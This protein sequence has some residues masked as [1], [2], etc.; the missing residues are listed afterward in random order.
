M[1]RTALAVVTDLFFVAKLQGV[2]RS[3]GVTL[4]VAAPATAANACETL[5]PDVVLVDLHSTA[6]LPLLLQALKRATSAPLIGFYSHVDGETRRIALESGID[7]AMP[8]SA[9]VTR[10]AELLTGNIAPATSEEHP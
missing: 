4:H 2:A 8:R 1:N 9:F 6:E 10:L 5:A 7:R 3:A